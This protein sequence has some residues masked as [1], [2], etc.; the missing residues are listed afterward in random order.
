MNAVLNVRTWRVGGPGVIETAVFAGSLVTGP[1]LG[2]ALGDEGRGSLAAVLVPVQLLGWGLVLGVPYASAMLSRRVERRDLFAGAWAIVATIVLPVCL[3]AALVAPRLLADQPELTVGWFRFGLIGVLLVMPAGVALQLR[4]VERGATWTHAVAK[5]LY[6]VG[7][8]VSVVGLAVLDRLTLAS[9]LAA[10]LVSYTAAPA[11]LLLTWRAWPTVR[12]RWPVSRELLSVGRSEALANVATISLGRLDQ[13]FL[14]LMATSAEL[15]LYAVAATAAMVSLPMAK[16]VADVIFPEAF[17]GMAPHMVDRVV[18]VTFAVST[19][20]AVLSAI[21]APWLLPWLFG[22]DFSGSVSLLWLMLPG[23]VLFNTG[24]VLGASLRG[25]GRANDVASALGAAALV[26]LLGLGPV[27]A[28]FGPHGAAGLTSL[29]QAIFFAV[30]WHLRP[31][32]AEVSV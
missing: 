24:W 5:N 30:V 2:H 28:V 4:L 11:V 18:A 7:Y 21:V 17:N 20:V 19:G 26:N 23:Q 22:D 3:G 32:T 10:W 29:C 14:A 27:I 9:A 16:G 1:L 31:W 13:F 15:G 12:A 6:L 8:T 25:I